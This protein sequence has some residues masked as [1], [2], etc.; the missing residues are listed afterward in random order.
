MEVACSLLDSETGFS[1][2]SFPLQIEFYAVGNQ[3][4]RLH[5]QNVNQN[6]R[7]LLSSI[8]MEPVLSSCE[9]CNAFEDLL[10]FRSYFCL[11][12]DFCQPAC[13]FAARFTLKTAP[14]LPWGMHRICRPF[15]LKTIIM[16]YFAFRETL[17]SCATRSLDLVILF[18]FIFL[19]QFFSYV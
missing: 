15:F 7:V 16:N 2:L 12:R 17:M 9:E 19:H 5:S 6:Q 4:I 1:V 10:F 3:G 14:K 8:Y 11:W 13:P 18:K